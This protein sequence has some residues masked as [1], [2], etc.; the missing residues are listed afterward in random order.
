MI[1]LLDN[2]DS[3]TYNIAHALGE[4]GREVSVIRSDAVDVE[5]VENMNPEAVVISPGPGRPDSAGESCR[6]IR[7]LAGRI[8]ILGVCL[9]HQ[10]LAE[11][12]GAEV[13][14]ARVPVHG[15][16]SEIFHDGRT[17]FSGLARPFVAARYHSLTVTPETVLPPLE[18]SATTSSGE[19]MGLRLKDRRAEGVQFHPESIAG[20][21]ARKVFRNF[22]EAYQV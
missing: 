7:D 18:I 10:C 6:I 19:V 16:T 9:G 20:R 4:L 22:L 12:F 8:P 11:V 14:R 5:Q 2:Y 3:F 21:E 17:V 15:K 13:T 1:L